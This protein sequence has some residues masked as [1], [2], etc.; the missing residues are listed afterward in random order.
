M[1]DFLI[2]KQKLFIW[3]I[4]AA[5]LVIA[6]STQV[7]AQDISLNTP[8]QGNL[9]TGATEDLTFIAREGQML[10]FILHGDETFDPILSITD[11]NGKVLVSNDD[12]E[13]PTSRDA[14]IEAFSA[15]YTGTYTLTISAYGDT[16]GN[17]E[18]NM[19]PGYSDIAVNETFD[20]TG[21]WSI[22]D[23]GSN[24]PA[25]L[26]IINGHA[27]L[28]HEGLQQEAIAVGLSADSDTYYVDAKIA[29]ISGSRGWQV[30]LVF[31]YQDA[32]NYYQVLINQNGAWRMTKV[33]NSAVTTL[34]NWNVHPAI[35]PGR[36][37]FD[38]GL[39]VN[40]TGF[41]V[42]Y[43]GQFIGSET[44]LSFQGG[45][46]GLSIVTPDAIGS[47]VTARY[48]S[49]LLTRPAKIDDKTVFPEHLV[50]SNMNYTVRELER[51]LVIPHGGEL[52]FLL[53]ESFVQNV[54]I[55]VSRFPIGN[56]Q[57]L[58]NFVL[59]ATIDWAASGA[60]LNGCGIT[61]DS[62]NA[63]D[64][65]IAY[66]DSTGSYGLAERRGEAFV[67]N[68]FKEAPTLQLPPY[69]MILVVN[70]DKVDY[71]LN[72]NHAASLTISQSKTKISE[73]V[74]NFEAA[75]TNCQ[76][77]DLWVWHW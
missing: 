19:L 52:A 75:N 42:F 69:Q 56:G 35:T 68:V 34:R 45:Q 13:Y 29:S 62:D 20:T 59:S 61:L 43:D 70:G 24:I 48:D 8:V 41:D 37:S 3:M 53:P 15:P 32:S 25:Q 12:Y 72:G 58:G 73:A 47:R 21:D 16:S 39:L 7:Q 22:I 66:V 51:R 77:N 11:S 17:Y 57:T 6:V 74:V 18:L 65:T 1:D 76:Y 23:L 28:I 14:M 9:E 38:L 63:N 55:G 27:N 26:T 2:R 54:S 5:W 67:Q 31:N 30:G 40:G 44:D 33:E 64:Y 71:F 60:D 49:L 36:D 4:C 50:A 46:V 10:S